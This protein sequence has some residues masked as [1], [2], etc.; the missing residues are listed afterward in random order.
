[1]SNPRTVK[2][3]QTTRHVALGLM[4]A[5]DRSYQVQKVMYSWDSVDP[6]LTDWERQAINNYFDEIR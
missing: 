4:V 1:M 5:G 3:S 2:W 6:D